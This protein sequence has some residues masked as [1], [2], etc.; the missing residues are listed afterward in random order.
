MKTITKLALV[1]ISIF[2]IACSK[3]SN[4]EN[5]VAP[6]ID[7]TLILTKTDRS[8]VAPFR[9]V[10]QGFWWCTIIEDVNNLGADKLVF[11]NAD[12][13]G[14]N[15]DHGMMIYDIASNTFV[16]KM[17][18]TEFI[19]GNYVNRIIEEDGD[20]YY[21]ADTFNKY[22]VATNTWTSFA[23]NTSTYPTSV[24]ASQ[25]K[26]SGV[27]VWAKRRIYYVGGEGGVKTVKYL[28]LSQNGTW[29]FA[30]D[31]PIAVSSGPLL[32]SD[33]GKYIY[34]IGGEMA[35]GAKVKNFYVYNI[36]SN[37]W[38]AL[39]DAPVRPR[40]NYTKNA[41]VLYKSRYL[42]YYGEDYKLRIYDTTTNKWQDNAID[43]GLNTSVQMEVASDG[44]K[45]YV[46]Y[47]KDN[48]A[49]GIQE[50]K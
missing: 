36:N 40:L 13:Q 20:L 8:V 17:K 16:D 48:G 33:I 42:V 11:H 38:T 3:S 43:T 30:A 46:V 1:A 12:D 27:K 24:K 34:A 39:E 2:A 25:N 5:A 49:V 41:M 35:G 21:I 9:D 6:V 14:N 7:N 50:Y 19:A 28:D 15:S 31:Y 22:V 37:S 29:N 45:F 26:A 32:A 4:D 10:S 23:A 18:S 44:S 47:R